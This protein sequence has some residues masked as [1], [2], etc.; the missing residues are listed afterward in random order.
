MVGLGGEK[1]P[2]EN[3]ERAK[4][5]LS[6][7]AKCAIVHFRVFYFVCA[8]CK[9][10]KLLNV[11]ER[12]AHSCAT[13][14]RFSLSLGLIFVFFCYSTRPE[15]IK[16]W[17]TQCSCNRQKVKQSIFSN[18]RPFEAVVLRL[19]CDPISFV[20]DKR[21]LI[22]NLLS[23]RLLFCFYFRASFDVRLDCCAKFSS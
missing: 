13:Q 7:A 23:I 6:N 2:K 17:R 11:T 14:R 10:C 18:L 8:K 12:D 21:C 3:E 1:K 19:Y 15:L 16:D 20:I 22:Y 5:T 4:C 9:K